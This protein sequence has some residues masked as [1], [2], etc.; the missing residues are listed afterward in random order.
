MKY[1]SRASF[2]AYA[3]ANPYFGCEPKARVAT[4]FYTHFHRIMLVIIEYYIYF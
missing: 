1:D 3:F 4:S 2:L